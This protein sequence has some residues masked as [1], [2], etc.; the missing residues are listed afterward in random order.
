MT[1]QRYQRRTA[2]TATA[3]AAAAVLGATQV[4]A[5]EIIRWGS[6]VLGAGSQTTIAAMASVV[7]ANS[8]LELVE[9]VTGGPAENMRLL[10]QGE[11]EI[12]Q[13]TSG[14]AYDG[15]HGRSNYK[16]QG[17]TDIQGL[18]TLYPANITLAVAADSGMRTVDDLKGKRIAVGPPGSAGPKIVLAWLKAFGIAE[19]ADLVQIGYVE[20]TNALRAGSVDAAFIFATGNNPAGFTQE[21]DLAMDIVPIEWSTEGEGFKRLKEQAPEMAVPGLIEAGALKNL[22]R[23]IQV[24]GTYSIEYTTG[25][26]SAETAY[27]VV[28]AI[29]ENRKEIGSRVAIAQWYGK[30]AANMLTGLVP[31]V[32]VHPGAAR[33]YK[34]VGVWDDRFTVGSVK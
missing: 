26:M 12:G 19:G 1:S 27:A 20:G 14:I 13:L 18:F 8:E 22:D 3:V 31:S 11:I 30:D 29:W 25:A 9:Q 34:E 6:S 4:Y 15:Y 2:L 7:T 17:K 10:Q 33:F 23:D 28:K 32:P 21:L 5:A 24:P 16:A